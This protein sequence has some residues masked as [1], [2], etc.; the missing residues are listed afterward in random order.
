MHLK[1]IREKQGLS[2]EELAERIGCHVN[3][4]RRWES[5]QREPRASDIK[6]LSLA[7]ECT[8]AELLNGVNDGKIKVVIS[9]DWEEYEKEEIDMD[10]NI[11][12]LFMGTEGQI[13]M[14]GAGRPMTREE[15]Q[16]L[17]DQICSDLDGMFELQVKR[18]AIQPA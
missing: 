3:T 12:K 4:I 8:E 2:Q 1:E 11:F 5:G 6:R 10:A 16:K 14:K 15:L 9:Y 13:G 18:G 7:L 17:K